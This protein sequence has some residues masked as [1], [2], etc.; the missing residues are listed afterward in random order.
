MRKI[1]TIYHHLLNS[2]YADNRFQHTQQELSQKFSFSLSTVNHA[3]V[4][5][6]QLGAVRKESKY[7]VLADF[8]K[9]IY[10]WASIR[11]LGK[12]IVY[13]THIDMPVLDIEASIPPESIFAGYSA[14][15]L[16]LKEPPAD[17][18]KVYFYTD[19]ALDLLKQRFP[20][21]PKNTAA[22]VLV[23][24]L[25]LPMRLYGPRTTLPQTFVDIWN[26]NDWY[27]REFTQELEGKFHGLL[28]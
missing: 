22:N 3:L 14:G 18:D 4:V 20:P 27:A 19:I 28:S 15:R 23:L 17:Y 8:K 1:E 26:L 6:Q 9:L 25:A 12:D 13:T 11:N 10:Y 24:K 5:P 7:F 2:A 21:Q 16:I